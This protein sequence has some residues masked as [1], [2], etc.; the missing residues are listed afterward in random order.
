MTQTQERRWLTTG[1]VPVTATT[2][3]SM[4]GASEGTDWIVESADGTVHVESGEACDPP[5]DLDE[6]DGANG[7]PR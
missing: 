1:S 2:K 5:A 4:Y 7:E 6:D 3:V